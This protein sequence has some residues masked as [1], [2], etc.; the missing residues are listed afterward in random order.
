MESEKLLI[1]ERLR[2]EF[3]LVDLDSL[4]SF[5]ECYREGED[6]AFIPVMKLRDEADLSGAE[7]SMTLIMS[8]LNRTWRSTIAKEDWKVLVHADP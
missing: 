7:E 1:E 3:D 4:A 2:V 6:E 5:E 8:G